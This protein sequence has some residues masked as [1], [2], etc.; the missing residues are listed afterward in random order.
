MFGAP[1]CSQALLVERRGNVLFPATA[2]P[3]A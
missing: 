3:D 2:G 1:V